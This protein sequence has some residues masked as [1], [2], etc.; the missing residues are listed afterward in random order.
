LVIILAYIYKT[1]SIVAPL[2]FPSFGIKNI[3]ED[4]KTISQSLFKDIDVLLLPA[5]TDVTPSIEKGTSG[6]PQALS[7]DNTFFCNYYGLPAIN[8]PCG[9]SKKGLP[10]DLQ[11]VKPRRVKT[12]FYSTA[13]KS[14]YASINELNMYYDSWYW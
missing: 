5:T 1:S 8:I 3:N 6:R 4:R 2:E 11:I 10:V 12:K 14:S 7:A 9:F 13:S